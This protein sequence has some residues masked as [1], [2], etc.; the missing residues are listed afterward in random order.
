[1]TC[2]IK[3]LVA[4]G[5][6]RGKFLGVLFVVLICVAAELSPIAPYG[7]RNTVNLH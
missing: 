5:G 7:R 2:K 3:R 6:N 4:H 1:M